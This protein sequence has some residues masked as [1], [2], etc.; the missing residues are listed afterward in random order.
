MTHHAGTSSDDPAAVL[1]N[2]IRRAG[3]SDTYNR[4]EELAA[5][6]SLVSYIDAVI[7]DLRND[8]PHAASTYRLAVRLASQVRP[9]RSCQA[10]HGTARHVPRAGAPG[11]PAHPSAAMRSSRSSPQLPWPVDRPIPTCDLWIR[12]GRSA[13]LGTHPPGRAAAPPTHTARD[14]RL[15]TARRIPQLRDG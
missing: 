10:R 2:A 7:A 15:A 8:K 4:V 5:E 9:P 14:N 13:D 6:G 12:R 11:D 3:D 1:A